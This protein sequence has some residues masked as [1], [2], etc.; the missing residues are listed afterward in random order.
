MTDA[1]ITLKS[2]DGLDLQVRRWQDP[3]APRTWT[4]VVVHGLGEHSGRYQ[5]FAEWFA[6]RGA[7]VYAMD[8]RGHGRSGGQRGHTPS[9]DALID[10]IDRVVKYARD[11]SGGPLVLV[12]HS[13]GGLLGIAYAL[14][15][16]DHIDRCVFSAPALKVKV[17]VPAFKRA[18]ARVLPRV[19]PRLSMSN[20]VNA[21]L[22]SHDPA[23]DMS[24][25]T[26][27]LVHNRISA[28]LYG[29]TFARGESLIARAA[30]LRVPFLLLHGTQD[31]VI[32]PAGSQRF[33]PRATAPERAF[34]LYPGMYHEIFNEVE[35]EMVFQD[36][37]SWLTQRTDAHLT[38]WNPPP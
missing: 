9:M 21:G 13:F 6:E 8:L 17:E 10:D 16:P 27:P 14:R 32:D 12:A 28:G 29:E 1:G 35:W 15:H 2:A 24:Y 38:G 20:E 30:E 23:V 33:F 18:L 31:M 11:E 22:L 19:A 34:I 37:E 3:A 36:I 7:T 5:R 26:D 25:R 4:F